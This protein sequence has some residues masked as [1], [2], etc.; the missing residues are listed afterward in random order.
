MEFKI[1]IQ[2]TETDKRILIALCLVLI[3]V[4]VIIGLLGS[5][6]IRTMRWQGKKCDTLVSDVVVYKIV[7]T[8]KQ[9]KKYARKKNAR[10]FL[11]QAWLPL[12]FVSLG[13]ITLII[14]NIVFKNWA[15]N[16][17]NSNDGFGTLLFLWDF[18]D[19]D[20]YTTIFG[21]KVLAKWPPLYNQPHVTMDAIYSYIGVP[22]IIIGGIWYIVAAQAYLARTIRANKLSKQVFE[23]S[24]EGVNG[25]TFA[26]ANT[27]QAPINQNI[28]DNQNQ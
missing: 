8:P 15:Y 7:T 25:N 28:S 5:L 20:S 22:L 18:N 10:Y 19:P 21:L 3:L 16:P 26:N 11:K 4:F 2:L 24:L 1:L 14:H 6:I 9:L 12:L 27:N 23:K 17:F 13:A